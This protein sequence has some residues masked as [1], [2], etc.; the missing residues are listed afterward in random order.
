MYNDP[1]Q[2][3]NLYCELYSLSTDRFIWPEELKDKENEIYKY[4][5]EVNGL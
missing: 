5:K 1:E 3:I 4:W 2:Y